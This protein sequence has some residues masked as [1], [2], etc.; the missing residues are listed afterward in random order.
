MT[1]TACLD[2][3]AW[4]KIF[5]KEIDESLIQQ[6]IDIVSSVINLYEIFVKYSKV[7]ELKAIEMIGWVKTKARIVGVSEDL[8]LRAAQLK[9]KYNFS[10]ADSIILATAEQEKAELITA[11]TDFRDVNEVKVTLL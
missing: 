2:R 3:S 8:A 10:M 6:D 9:K 11:D 1:Q 5:D 7:S 4:I